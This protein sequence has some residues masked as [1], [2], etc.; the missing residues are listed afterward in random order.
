MANRI[1]DIRDPNLFQ[2]LVHALFTA[3]RGRDFQIVDD[4]SGDRGNDGYDP[5]AGWLLAIYCPEKG[6]QKERTLAK[7]RADLAKATRLKSDPGY[8]IVEWVFVTPEALPERVQ[9]T[10]RAEADAVG[11]RATFLSAVNLESS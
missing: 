5:Q 1:V 2:R 6:L 8:R 4:G 9:A 7:A 10:L 3:E 11:L